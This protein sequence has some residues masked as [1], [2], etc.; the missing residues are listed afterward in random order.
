MKKIIFDCDNTIGMSGCDVDDGLALIYLLGYNPS[1][2]LGIT[3]TYGNS[4]LTDVY[5]NTK[6][7]L[8]EIGY[9]NIPLLKGGATPGDYK[10][11][12]AYFLV[13]MANK[14]P[15]EL[16]VLATGSLTNLQG[17]YELDPLFFSKVKEIVLMGGITK[18]LVFKKKVMDE[19]NFSCDPLATYNVLSYGKNVSVITGNNCLKAL[20]TKEE[21]K[22]KLFS[23]SNPIGKYIEEKTH[24]WFNDNK[25]DYGI[26]GFY[27]WDVIAAVYLINP[28]L[29]T[30]NKG[31]FNISVEDLKTGFL[32]KSE[33]GISLNLPEIANEQS[34]KDNIYSTW[35]N[36]S[37]K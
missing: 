24:Y 9:E 19:L 36:L 4:I 14:Y 32:G 17:A 33:K 21:Y 26:D 20:F 7:F 27:N 15:K 11:P 28:N 35:L 25:I 37:I 31:S 16:S 34:L 29:F 12:A 18:P 30:D 6:I 23:N 1:Y 3:T 5:E 13:D 10:N 2:V 22:A 8:K